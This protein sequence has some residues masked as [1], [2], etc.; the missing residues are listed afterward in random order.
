M[1]QI[2]KVKYPLL[3]SIIMLILFISI[4]S[5]L[6]ATAHAQTTDYPEGW[7]IIPKECLSKEYRD[8]EGLE[9]GL[10]SFLKLFVNMSNVALK[11]LPYL[12]MIMVIWAGFNLIMAGG[13]P[14][15]I[16]SGKKMLTSV[17]LGILI[18]LVLAWA[19]S[20]FIV[21]LLTCDPKSETECQAKLFGNYGGIWE[22]E[23]WGGDIGSEQEP[24]VGCC[25]LIDTNGD[26]LAC[27]EVTKEHCDEL[28]NQAGVDQHNFELQN[29]LPGLKKVCEPLQGGC[30]VEEVTP[31][32]SSACYPADTAENSMGCV[33]Y[34]NTTHNPNDCNEI[35]D[36]MTNIP[37]P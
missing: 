1:F 30:C 14:E 2:T 18:M 26:F 13:N 36:C 19:W 25:T 7:E 11:V 20:Y 15:K 10:N 3:F 22:K 9:C 37:S 28:G 17:F 33:N 12:T 4:A 21:Y 27:T 16:Q 6:P 34:P 29:C 5:L 32:N 31:P 8:Q 23:W 35:A 24:D